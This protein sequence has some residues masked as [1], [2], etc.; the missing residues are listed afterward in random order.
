MDNEEKKVTKNNIEFIEKKDTKIN[1]KPKKQ[2]LP[3]VKTNEEKTNFRSAIWV[4]FLFF[5][6]FVVLIALPYISNY[7]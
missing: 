2:K 5:I 3:N 7:R 4:I 1:Q 6:L